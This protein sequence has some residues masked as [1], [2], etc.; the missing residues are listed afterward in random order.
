MQREQIKRMHCKQ[1]GKNTKHERHTTAMGCGDLF[2][3]VITL[4]IWLIFRELFKPRF[5]CSECGK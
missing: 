2:M 3:V 5:H 1:C 4:G